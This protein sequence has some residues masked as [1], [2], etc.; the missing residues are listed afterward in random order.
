MYCVLDGA[1]SIHSFI[2]LSIYLFIQSEPA[3]FFSEESG[4][5][6]NLNLEGVA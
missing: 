5:Q 6:R 3:G 2:Y 4:F 1:Y